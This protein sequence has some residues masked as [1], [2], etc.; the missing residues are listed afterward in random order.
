MTVEKRLLSHMAAY[1][2]LTAAFGLATA[3]ATF[4][5]AMELVLAGLTYGIGLCYLDDVI[6]FSNSMAKHCDR[7]RAELSRF[8]QHNLHLNLSKCTLAARKVDYLGHVI[9]KEGVS[10]FQS[11]VEAVKQIPVPTTVKES[12]VF[13]AYP[14][15]GVLSRTMQV[16]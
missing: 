13:S 11:K 12:A 8:Q 4:Q 2:K 7:L 14:G 9:S 5:R 10:L 16:L 3:P 1:I 15:T 6:I